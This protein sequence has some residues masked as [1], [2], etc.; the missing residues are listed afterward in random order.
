MVREFYDSFKIKIECWLMSGGVQSKLQHVTE[1]FVNVKNA[2]KEIILS[3]R[4]QPTVFLFS[5]H[6]FF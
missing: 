5:P 2:N 3:L 4:I 1:V 6:L